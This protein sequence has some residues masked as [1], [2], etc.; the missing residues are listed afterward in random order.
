MRRSHEVIGIATLTLAI[1]GVGS[2][3]TVEG[4]AAGAATCQGQVATIVGMPRSE[5]HGT[6]GPDVIVTNGA[7]DI[8]AGD[9]DDLVCVTGGAGLDDVDVLADHGDDIVDASASEADGVYVSLRGG[10]DTFVGGPH[11]DVVEASDPWE[12]TRSGGA[13]SVSTAGGDDWVTT[14]GGPGDIDHDVIDLGSGNDR[15]QLDGPVDPGLPIL[16]GVGSD[17]LV[18]NRSTMRQAWVIDNLAGRATRA[19]DPVITWNGI[20]SFELTPWGAWSAPSFIGSDVSEVVYS[21]IPLTSVDLGGGNDRVNLDLHTRRLV[22]EATYDGGAGTDGF[23]LNAGAGDQAERVDLDLV[24]GRLL[25]RPEDEPV[26]AQIHRFERYRLSAWRLDVMGTA[27]PEHV[28]WIGCRGVVGGGPGDDV[29]QAIAPADVGCGYAGED[30]EAIARG[31]RGDDTLIGEYMPDILIGGP[32]ND[33]ANG[34]RNDDRCIAETEV[35]CD[36]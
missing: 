9:G 32:G 24:D 18:L 10:D 17:Q 25:F 31:G 30:A 13:D 26:A 12:T 8:Y 21:V 22:D 14:G 2:A 7:A 35:R 33:Y 11:T 28:L 3:D 15:V 5:I 29:L 1:V 20:E 4:A 23:S 6:N 16:A 27:A 34:R 19:G 36:R